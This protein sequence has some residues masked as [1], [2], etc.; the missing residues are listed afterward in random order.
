[1]KPEILFLKQ[2]DVITAGVLDMKKILELVEKTFYLE[3]IGKV[4]NPPKTVFG[5]PDNEKRDSRFFTMPVY[6]G[7]DVNRPGVK[8]AAESDANAKNGDLPMGVD[9][10]VLSDPVT[11]LPVAILDGMVITAMRTAAAAGVAAKYLAQKGAETVGCV[12]AGVIGRTMIMALKEVLPNLKKVKICDLNLEKAKS[13]ATEFE[14]QIEVEPVSSVKEAV[15]G[16]DVIATMTTSRKPFVKKEWVKPGCMVIQM[17]SCEVEEGVVE[18]AGKI[19]V[20]SWDQ[21]KENSES[22]LL[23]M[24]EK[25]R[26]DEKSVILLRDVV[27]GNKP[28]RETDDETTMFSSRGMGCLDIMIGDF[29]YKNA[30]QK[31]LGQI[32]SLWDEPKWV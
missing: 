17:S 10:V 27:C 26:L 1:L 32:L 9:L 31:G 5:I 18:K 23:Q 7:G 3:G 11:V 16:Q 21:I 29:L 15:D 28:G 22:V 14:G 8:W 19:V 24:L 25:G 13:L 4:N 30:K 6:I 20:D 12:G 2:E